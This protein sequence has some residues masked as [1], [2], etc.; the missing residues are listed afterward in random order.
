MYVVLNTQINIHN[1]RSINK[2]ISNFVQLEQIRRK[3]Q[4]VKQNIN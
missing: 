4:T 1:W 3:C 2:K